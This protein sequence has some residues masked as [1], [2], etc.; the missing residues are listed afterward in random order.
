VDLA[1][2]VEANEDRLAERW[3]TEVASRSGPW[4]PELES[5]M[6]RFLHSFVS[7]L[8]GCL[9]PLRNQIQPLWVQAAELY[10][11]LGSMRALAAGDIIEEFQSLR[12]GLIRALHSDPPKGG[13]EPISLRE[14][15]L[16][17]RIVDRGVTQASVGHTD[18]LFFALIEGS[19]L[20]TVPTGDVLHEVGEQLDALQAERDTILA[21]PPGH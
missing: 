16:L 13:A 19:G 21:G 18:A 1:E 4:N 12:D 8:P 17:N 15:L 9:G 11:S 3:L 6:R 10:G 2:W 14:L 20:A 7:L 5:L